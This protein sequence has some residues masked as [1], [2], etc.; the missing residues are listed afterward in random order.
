MSTLLT[1]TGR[2]VD[3][4]KINAITRTEC[5]GVPAWSKRRTWA[6]AGI[7][8]LANAFFRL[9]GNPVRILGH[10]TEWHAWEL[11]SLR[12]L[13]GERFRSSIGPRSEVIVES[14]PGISISQ[15]L[16]A[17][18]A[19]PGMFAAAAR[20]L[21]RA[22]AL[23]CPAFEGGWS[24]GDPHSGNLI[25]D[26][27]TDTARLID[28][29]VQHHRTL[30]AAARHTDDLLVFLQDTLGRLPRE[31]WLALAPVFVQAY[32]CPAITAHLVERLTAPRGIARLWWA[33]RTTYLAPKELADRLRDL[34]AALAA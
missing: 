33:V 32:D 10:P 14:L 29:E 15:H 20:E 22:H 18:T 12:L 23:P 16:D 17:G 7:I 2:L 21:R 30:P 11:A 25:F 27:A 9:V 4:I 6:S 31:R 8:P 24:H 19:T 13:H 28:F 1:T 34:R 5:G 3:R 26:A